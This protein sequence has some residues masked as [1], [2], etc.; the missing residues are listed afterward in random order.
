M[1]TY[2]F[3]TPN[4][5]KLY[6]ELRSGELRV[7]AV[8]TDTT[9]VEVTG[10]GAD[11]ITVEQD[12]D[13]ITI[14]DPKQRISFGISFQ[15]G[16]TVSV[17][18]PTDSQ[19]RAK[20]GSADI[21]VSGRTTAVW[22]QSGSGEVEVDEVT[23]PLEATTGSGDI[24]IDHARGSLRAKS[25]SGDLYVSTADGE[26]DI[27]TGSGDVKIRNAHGRVNGK[28]GSGDLNVEDAESDVTLSTGS[29]DLTVGRAH[30]GTILG[31]GASGDIRIGVPSGVPVWTDITT[32][33]GSIRSTLASAGQPEPGQDH[34]ELRARTVSGDII[35]EQV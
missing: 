15:T 6:T 33:S 20:T 16:P 1:P 21:T 19:V 28:T 18:V 10:K 34:V 9:T 26:V 7:T 23:G 8:D 13:Q 29:G 3:S 2:T 24:R 25:G 32:V 22:A 35:L 31:K 17:T 4:P 5:A 11:D 30:R 14:L 27:S 12:G